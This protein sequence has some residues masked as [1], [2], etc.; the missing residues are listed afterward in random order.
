MRFNWLTEG[1]VE[2]K[3]PGDDK[4]VARDPAVLEH[5]QIQKALL[6]PPCQV[7]NLLVYIWKKPAVITTSMSRRIDKTLTTKCPGIN[8]PSHYILSQYICP[9]NAKK[10]LYTKHPD[11]TEEHPAKY[12]L[13]Q[14]M[15]GKDNLQLGTF[16]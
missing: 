15:R 10:R 8:G 9:P 16:V 1:R 2:V 7:A 3:C 5:F 11:H 6:E 14:Y 4:W 13:V 12:L